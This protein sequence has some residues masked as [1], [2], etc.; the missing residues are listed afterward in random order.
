MKQNKKKGVSP[1]IATVLLI[2]IVIILAVI[3]L[4]WSRGFVKEAVLKTIGGN[5]K[6]I[7]KFCGDVK[8]QKILDE[9]SGEVGFS[10]LG[11]IPIYGVNVKIVKDDGSSEIKRIEKSGGGRVN[12][13][14]STI[15]K[16]V[17]YK[18]SDKI[19][20]TP[21]LMGTRKSGGLKDHECSDDWALRV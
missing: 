1:I 9:N 11:N 6:D 4:L 17:N 7:A 20:I 21:I 18:N 12:P 16:G 3:I 14:I 19:Y 5:R 10:N 15:L 2:L 8:M 13:G